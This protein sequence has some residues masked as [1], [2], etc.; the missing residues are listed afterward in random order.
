MVPCGGGPTEGAQSKFW[1]IQNDR[2]RGRIVRTTPPALQGKFQLTNSGA[3]RCVQLLQ[4]RCVDAAVR[5]EPMTRLKP[6]YCC[7]QLAFIQLRIVGNTARGEV[8]DPR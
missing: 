1:Q 5:L 8:S 2:R 6:L 4:R 3:E 7:H